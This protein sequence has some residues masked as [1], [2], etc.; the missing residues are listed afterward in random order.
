MSISSSAAQELL[1]LILTDIMK[2]GCICF[3]MMAAILGGCAGVAE[4]EQALG[5][6]ATV[7]AFCRAVAAGDMEQA[8]MLCNTVSMKEYLDVWTAT[9]AELA[10]KDSSA[11]RIASGILSQSAFTLVKVEKESD[12]RIITY[13]LETEGHSKNRKAVVKKEEGEWRVESMTDVQ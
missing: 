3:I 10:Q 7:E 6:E 12:R 8:G 13:T 4:K 9:W 1:L 2:R 11:L 5:P